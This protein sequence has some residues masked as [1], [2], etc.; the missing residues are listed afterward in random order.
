MLNLNIS[1]QKAGLALGPLLFLLILLSDIEGMSW[2]AKSIAASTVWIAC[3]WLT[4]AI[5]IPATSLLPIILFP[6]LG[7]LEVGKVTAEYGN[8]IIFLL[9]G[10]FFIAIAME[11][12]KLHVRIALYIVNTIGTSPRRT[13][14]GFMAATAF[15]SA[16]ISNTATAM[17][18]VPIA[19][20]V[21]FQASKAG[22]DKNFNTAIMLSVA[23]AASIGGIATLIGTTP[24]LIFAGIYRTFYGTEI[25]FLQWASFGFPLAF[26]ILIVCWAYLVYFAYPPKIKALGDGIEE[27]IKKLGRITGQEKRVLAV[28]L[29]VASL[30][31]TRAL[32]GKYLPM[33]TDSGIAIFGAFLLFLIP[34]GKDEALLKWKD[35]A[36]L[37]WDVVLLLGG[38]L[39]IAKGFT[40][41]GLDAWIANQLIFLEGMSVIVIILTVV[42]LTIFLTEITSNTATATI[43][44]PVTASLAF[45]LGMEPAGLMMAAAISASLAFMLPVATPPNAI[46]YGTGYVTIP[47]MAKAGV[48]MNLFCIAIITLYIYAMH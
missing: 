33:I 5:P 20:A 25:T 36:K 31:V 34:A 13:I 18:M 32:W 8:Q 26:F 42:T 23:Y 14:A 27:E 21:I 47:Q 45:A 15:I 24:N 9:I 35:A 1:R 41:T 11:K 44:L 46:V 30:W 38:G 10:G 4:E 7:A 29:L 6:L 40:E 12:W 22:E 37:P 39:A 2:E 3:W 19:T 16:W 43:I 48:W 17:M 28:F